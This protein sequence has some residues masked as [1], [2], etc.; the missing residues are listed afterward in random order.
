MLITS[1]NNEHI[2]ELAKLKEKKYRQ[3][4]NS[5]LVEGE[6]LVLEAYKCG[7]IKELILKEDYLFPIPIKPTYVTSDILKKLSDNISTPPVMAVV[8]KKEEDKIGEKVLILDNI[9]DP[10]NLGTIIRSCVA[11]NIDTLILSQDTVDLYN[12]KVI[13]STQGMIFHLNIIIKKLDEIIPKLKEDGYKIIGTK[14]THGKDIKESKTYSH[15]AI[16]LGNEGTGIKEEILSLCDEYIYIKT[17]EKCESL[18][19][20]V[21][22][23]IILY[24]LNNKWII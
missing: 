15:Y 16:I 18:N 19:V 6:H 12:P 20:G 8:S 13:R 3:L 10:G 1:T 21:A 4:T 11:F 24:E 9:Q 17:N 14:V 22:G 5:F 23:S 7:L 2:K